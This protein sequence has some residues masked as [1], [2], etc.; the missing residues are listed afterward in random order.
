MGAAELSRHEVINLYEDELS[1][2]RSLRGEWAEVK[3]AQVRQEVNGYQD[4]QGSVTDR[5][6]G[7]KLYMLDTTL[8]LIDLE[9][10][11][12]HHEELCMFYRTLLTTGV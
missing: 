4:S 2:L 9:A 1:T 10:D 11:I 3:K 7:A 12:T 6:Q 8:D 5:R